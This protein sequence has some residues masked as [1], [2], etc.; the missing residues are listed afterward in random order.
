MKCSPIAYANRSYW[1]YTYLYISECLLWYWLKPQFGESKQFPQSLSL[2]YGI[3]RRFSIC[4]ASYLNAYVPIRRDFLLTILFEIIVS[5]E[6]HNSLLTRELE[7]D[8]LFPPC[9]NLQVW[10]YRKDRTAL[11]LSTMKVWSTIFR[12]ATLCSIY[13]TL[14]NIQTLNHFW[15]HLGAL[16][17]SSKHI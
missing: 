8:G 14:W 9:R 7:K 2:S 5:V 17:T 11:S 6:L 10:V 1:R 13:N 3:F 16:R 4:D 15:L 12:L